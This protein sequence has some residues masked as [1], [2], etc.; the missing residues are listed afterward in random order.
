LCLRWWQSAHIYGQKST[1]KEHRENDGS[2]FKNDWSYL[3]LFELRM[4]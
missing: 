2:H 3:G 1:K 4:G